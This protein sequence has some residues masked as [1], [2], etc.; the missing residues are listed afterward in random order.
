MENDV[1]AAPGE[2]LRS[3][4]LR[5]GLSQEELAERAGISARSVSD[6]ERGDQQRPFPATIRRLADSLALD[7]REHTFL[8]EALL[9]SRRL[10]V[11][12]GRGRRTPPHPIGG[13]LGASPRGPLVGRG[14][15]VRALGRAMD[16]VE[17][18]EGRFALL[19]GEA[20][21]GKTRLAQEASRDAH[22]RGFIVAFG[23]C[24]EP[25]QSA[26]FYPFLEILSTLYAGCS[27]DIRQDVQRRWPYV[28]RLLPE[29]GLP[30]P[31]SSDSQDE[32]ARL[33]R[34][35]GG[36]LVAIA[37]DAPVAILIDD[38]HWADL[39]SLDLLEHLA[40][41]TRIARVLLV[42]TY[43]DA[44]VRRP[45]RLS[46]IASAALEREQLV[47][48]IPLNRLDLTETRR[49]AAAETGGQEFADAVTAS[50]HRVTE[51]NPFFIHEV[52]RV[53]MERGAG[54]AGDDGAAGRMDPERVAVPRTVRDAIAERVARLSPA[55]QTVL[56]EASVLGQTF[57]LDEL[58]AIG[59]YAEAEVES[60]LEE[61]MTLGL[62]QEEGLDDY[63]F[64][65]ALTQ[66]SLYAELTSRRRRRLHLAAGEA[67]ERLPP[68]KR[69]ARAADLAWHFLQGNDSL[70]A[71]TYSLQSGDQTEAVFAHGEAEQHYLT[72]LRL[73]E[74]LRDDVRHA[75]AL[76]KLG[77]TLRRLGRLEEG[78]VKL[79]S[80]AQAYRK[81]GDVHSEARTTVAIG[82]LHSYRG[83]VDAGL[84]VIHDFLSR[85]EASL[86]QMSRVELACTRC[87][88]LGAGG[89]FA[90]GLAAAELAAE[91]LTGISLDAPGAARQYVQ[92]EMHRSDMLRDLGRSREANAALETVLQRT[93]MLRAVISSGPSPFAGRPCP[94]P[95]G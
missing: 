47:E 95:S 83:T 9:S 12:T 25:R 5:A 71:L 33:L 94:S 79:D 52:V 84:A 82:C 19:F 62:V 11:P 8:T 88:L 13:F 29:H 66:E 40:R 18:G 45:H 61:A 42:A 37:R 27:A 57:R 15:Q 89:R 2:V 34:A 3:Y 23:R 56:H 35:V 28:A 68:A 64:D 7:D 31:V 81:L 41:H 32:Q 69:D 4:R 36:F 73:T 54:A 58:A 43:R 53:L 49:L 63:S 30:T 6:I 92:V 46:T 91:L 90:E 44:E 65:H 21:I 77:V 59:R 39:A 70:R 74:G 85:T 55:A 87:N 78:L 1:A 67:L 51:G 48:R 80:A 76:E 24:Y 75:Q 10:G 14:Q 38:L 93:C 26:G 86:P 17:E 20:G 60:A 22:R 16:C 50:L 72:A